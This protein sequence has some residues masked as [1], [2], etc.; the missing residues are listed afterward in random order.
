MAAIGS[1]F[2]M[3]RTFAVA[4]MVAA[5]ASCLGIAG[6]QAQANYPDRPV[7]IILPFGPGGVADIT[8]RLVAQKLG[9]KLGQNFVVEN[10]PSAGGITAARAVLQAPADGYTLALF[11]NGTAISVALF[12]KLP[13]DPLTQFVPVSALGTFDLV[14]AVAA[15]SPFKTL[16]EIIKAA[17]DKPGSV[18]VG[19]ISVGSTQDLTAELF[20]A[21]SGKEFV[22]IPFRTSPDES[23]AL[24]RGDIQMMV[25]FYAALKPSL[26]SGQARA[27][28]TSNPK[29]SPELP[30]VPSAAEAGVPLFDVTS[31]NALYAPAGTPQPIIDKLNATLHDV[32]ADPEIKK[33]ALDLGID[34]AGSTP[35]DLGARMKADIEKW[36]KVIDSAHIPKQ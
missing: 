15:N 32:L 14:F 34:S 21:M 33:R 24:L 7:R 2:W 18:N 36:T 25:E 19:A 17:Q 8:T 29:R 11:T 4:L 13:F 10:M 16:G 26:E 28:A 27:L 1:T 6:A 9:E 3:R 35:A 30:D 12:N 20:K 23:V 31:W 22:I 5:A